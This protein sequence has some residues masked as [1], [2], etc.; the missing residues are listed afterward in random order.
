VLS[1]AAGIFTS[2]FLTSILLD[3][4]L[5]EFNGFRFG[6]YTFWDWMW[7]LFITV[8]PSGLSL[9]GSLNS[10]SWGG[11]LIYGVI[12]PFVASAAICVAITTIVLI[13]S[14]ITA[15]PAFFIALLIVVLASA[16]GTKVIYVYIE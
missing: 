11:V 8:F 16:T 3:W 13:I 14:A 4:D 10:S 15:A 1:L 12:L 5:R 7:L 2:M 9:Y 6:D